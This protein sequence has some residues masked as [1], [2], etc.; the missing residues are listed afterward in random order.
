V[1]GGGLVE[2]QMDHRIAM[3]FLTLGLGAREPVTVDDVSMIATSFP[4]FTQL[5][6]KL[7]A[8]LR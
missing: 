5:M 4:D 8:D 7:G 3:A 2:T 1:Q 6:T